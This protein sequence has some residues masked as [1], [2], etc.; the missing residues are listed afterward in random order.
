MNDSV[1]IA[2]GFGILL[3]VLAHA[4]CPQWMQHFI[5]M[6]HMPLFFFLSGY[7]FKEKYLADTK[8]FVMRRIKGLYYPYVKYSLLFLLLHN[9]FFY[10]NIY[11]GKYGFNGYVS[12]LYSLK[13]FLIKGI[14]IVSRM[15][16]QEQLLGGFWFLKQLLL[17]SIIGLF[18][19]K[20]GRNVKITGGVLIILTITLKWSGLRVPFFSID[21]LT[22]LSASFFVFGYIYSRIKIKSSLVLIVLFLV[23][24]VL[25]SCFWKATMLHN[26]TWNILPYTGTAILGSIAVYLLSIQIAKYNSIGKPVLVFIGNHTMPILVWHFLCFKLV[27]LLIIGIYDLPIQRLAEFPVIEEYAYKGWWIVY[28]FVGVITSLSVDFIFSKLQSVLKNNVYKYI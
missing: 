17:A 13:D 21:S 6:F 8:T 26:E 24:V 3:M 1:S 12:Q 15:S 18:S 2:K 16:G 25:G 23:T 19:I 20:Y 7:C 5:G 22:F 4:R 28:S 27:S 9:I 11:N 14:N 10:L